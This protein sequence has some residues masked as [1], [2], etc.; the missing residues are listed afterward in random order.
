MKSRTRV[1]EARLKKLELGNLPVPP[2]VVTLSHDELDLSE[3]DERVLVAQRAGGR[4]VAVLPQKCASTQEWIE[5]YAKP[6]L[7]RATH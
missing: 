3:A 1:L 7:A 2:Y 6:G 5:L 4:M